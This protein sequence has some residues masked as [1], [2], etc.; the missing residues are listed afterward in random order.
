MIWNEA[1]FWYNITGKHHYS[2]NPILFQ[3]RTTNSMTPYM[4]KEMTW[5]VNH[6]HAMEIAMAIYTVFG[7]TLHPQ[8]SGTI[9]TQPRL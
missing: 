3:I 6:N 7:W 8:P 1:N 2:K 5:V 9:L 4:S